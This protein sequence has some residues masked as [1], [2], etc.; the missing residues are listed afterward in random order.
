MENPSGKPGTK[1]R[2]QTAF[3]KDCVLQAEEALWWLGWE[4]AARG[5][6]APR[7]TRGESGDILQM[8]EQRKGQCSGGFASLCS[9]RALSRDEERVS[10]WKKFQCCVPLLNCPMV[11]EESRVPIRTDD[12][13]MP[14]SYRALISGPTSPEREPGKELVPGSQGW[15]H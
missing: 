1:E 11:P 13:T 6:W 10:M 15:G 2:C 14:I 4:G 7:K 9:A 12:T 8:G 5:T 3:K